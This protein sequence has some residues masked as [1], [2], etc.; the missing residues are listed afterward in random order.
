MVLLVVLVVLATYRV[1]RLF[2]ADSFPP[3]QAARD[4]LQARYGVDSWQ[5][6]LAECPWC[7]SV[8]VGGVFT[9]AAVVFARHGLVAPLLVWPTASALTGL[10]AANLDP[11]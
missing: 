5:A 8:Y 4:R 6:Y 9:L 2:V 7:V 3:V 10:I 11:E 1:T